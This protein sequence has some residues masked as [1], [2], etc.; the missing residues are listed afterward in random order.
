MVGDG[1]GELFTTSVVSNRHGEVAPTVLWPLIGI[2]DPRRKGRVRVEEA[3]KRWHGRKIRATIRH[4]ERT[5]GEQVITLDGTLGRPLVISIDAEGF[6]L[7]GFEV[8]KQDARVGV[9][10]ID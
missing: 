4:G 5:V 8:G 7:H 9:Y 6:V 1:D 3:L 2:Q 10:G